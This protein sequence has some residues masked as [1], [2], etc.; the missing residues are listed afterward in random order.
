MTSYAGFRDLA[1]YID[2]RCK[3]NNIA[4]TAVA[5]E[6]GW[7]RNYMHDVY[8]LK[9]RIS[10]ARANQLAK[11]FGDEP[12]LVRVLGDVEAPPSGDTDKLTAEIADLIKP[13]S[14][15]LQQKM[16]QLLRNIKD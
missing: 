8:H 9:F 13:L 3:E 10:R 6:L 2:Q 5:A 12:R 16:L 15:D 1:D 4:R 11:H 7:P 14:K